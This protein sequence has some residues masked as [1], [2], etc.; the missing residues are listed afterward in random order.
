MIKHASVVK[1]KASYE[2]LDLYFIFDDSMLKAFNSLVQFD[3]SGQL[4]SVSGN[5]EEN[6]KG[7]KEQHN[8]GEDILVAS[9][10]AHGLVHATTELSAPEKL[11]SVPDGHMDLHSGMMME[12]IPGDFEGLDEG[13]AGSKTAAGRKRTFTESTLTEQSLNSV[14]SSRQVRIKRTTG[15]V[16]DDD[17]LL[18]SILGISNFMFCIV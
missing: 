10:D 5:S 3:L 15:S 14:E 7:N 8:E 12:V 4:H 17:D 6:V 9:F 2:F 16:P 11:V 1:I 13:D 18:S